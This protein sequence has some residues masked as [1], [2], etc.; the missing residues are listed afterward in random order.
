[1]LDKKGV[2]AVRLSRLLLDNP[3][4]YRWLKLGASCL[5]AV[6]IAACGGGGG[7]S[8]TSAGGTSGGTSASSTITPPTGTPL[9]GTALTSTEFAALAPTGA[10]SGV[11]IAS[12]PVVTFQI[13]DANNRGIKGLGLTSQTS[14]AARPGLANLAFSIAKLVPGADGGPSK[15][16][17]Y[18]VTSSPTT[19]A[20]E[21]PTRPT[22]DNIGTLVDNGDGTYKYTFYRDVT[23]IKDVVGAATVT[24]PNK[25]ADL[26][27]LTYE[28][29]RLHRLVIQVG[30]N[31]RGTG[32]NTAD[33]SNSGVTAVPMGS[34]VNIVFDWYPATGKVAST[35][36]ADQRELVSVA[37]CNEC[38]SKLAFHGG[39]RV[40]TRYCVVCHTDQRKYGQT[41]ATS[42]AGKFPALKETATVNTT[43]GITSY[44]YTPSTYIADGETAGDFPVM[45]HKIH[46]GK[47]LVKQ[48]YNYA[49][50]VFNNKGY[51]MLDGGQRMCTKCHDS[52]KAAQADNWNAKP[53]RLACGACHDGINWATGGGSTLADKAAATAIGAVVATSGHVGK[54]QTG[55]SACALCHSA[56]AIKTYHQTAN[57]TM[58]N[59]TVEAG[60]K[61]FAYEI[62]SAAVDATTNDVTIV[63]KITA[64]GNPVTLLAAASGMANPLSGFTGSPGFLLA[65]AQT[66]DGITTPAD[67][68]NLGVKQAQAV[69]VSIANLLDTAKTA[70]GSLSAPTADGYYTATLKGTGTKK[71]PAGAKMRAV[72]LQGYFTQVAPAA[73]RHAISV[74]K[75]VTNDTVRRKVVDADKCANCHEWFEGHGGNRVYQT[76]VCVMCHVPGLAT[77]G[78]GMSDSAL[79]TYA[80]TAA[81]DKILKEWKTV[82]GFDKTL[83]N[84]ALKLPVTSNNFK[85]LIHGIHAGRE[86]V[87]PF[88]DARDRTPSAITLLDFRRMDFPGQLKKCDT[89][90]VAGSYASVPTTALA[91]TYESI[92]ATYA[93]GIAA[94][95][96]TPAQ[97]KTALNT[98]NTTDKVVSPFAA[99]CVTC[100][101]SSAAAAH[102]A[103]NNAMLGV[104][105]GT[106]Q[107]NT[108]TAG[109]GEACVTC[110]G[111]GKGEDVT[112]VHKR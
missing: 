58:H 56:A 83:P 6:A 111:A 21:A 3:Y 95:T 88:V 40:D 63:F 77:S 81:D 60:L 61:N 67:Y 34:P 22:T 100:H 80:F 42:T 15:W 32:S 33:G 102:M 1:M 96:A 85:D 84:A 27:D 26:G 57:V 50:V 20:A 71:F 23:K 73:A 36:D 17:S 47:E 52:A 59:S 51:S 75:E 101:D 66:Q 112:A 35:K 94:G 18:I 5:I 53:T 39:N 106:F 98:A 107:T 44:S 28:P 90:H 105:R 19:T 2:T 109:S 49:N 16:V 10:V 72:A 9:D 91:S 54:A 104:T 45:I 87:T 97:A 12:P 68:N 92:D 48:N 74:V 38:H 43:T 62:K 13:T 24:A 11:S 30:G 29:T 79:T 93:A 64:D 65:Y 110:H 7:T 86:R 14:T 25:V 8:T 78:R 89:C 82:F 76:Q 41:A 55:D 103:T 108:A 31:L 69:S 4:S 37:N 99:A 70:D 46:Q